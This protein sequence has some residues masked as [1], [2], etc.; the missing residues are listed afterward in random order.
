MNL[1]HRKTPL[2]RALEG[3]AAVST[4]R[5][6]APRGEDHCRR[7]RWSR[8]PHR[9]E[10]GRL[11]GAPRDQA[12]KLSTVAM[13][14]AGYVLGTRAGRQRYDQIRQ[15][16]GRLADEFD[17]GGARERFESVSS[18]LRDLRQATQE[19]LVRGRVACRAA[20]VSGVAH[21][22]EDSAVGRL[23]GPYAS[24]VTRSPRDG[25]GPML[26]RAVVHA[27]LLGLRHPDARRTSGGR[28][29]GRDA[30]RAHRP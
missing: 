29:A 14:G 20:G 10:R 25:D 3:L 24:G 15:L 18:R 16:A 2:E 17:G 8:D 21:V 11:V 5:S 1:F 23:G 28:G 22:D 9:A 30:A 7:A 26:I 13:F 27:R 12:V 4:S 6:G 19:R